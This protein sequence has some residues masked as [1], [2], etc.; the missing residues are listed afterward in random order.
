VSQFGFPPKIK[1]ISDLA[2]E[3]GAPFNMPPKVSHVPGH[4]CTGEAMSVPARASLEALAAA[5]LFALAWSLMRINDPSKGAIPLHVQ[6]IGC[7][8]P[9][10]SSSVER[11][12][13]SAGISDASPARKISI[14][15]PACVEAAV[16][17]A[18]NCAAA[19]DLGALNL[20]SAR[21]ASAACCSACATESFSSSVCFVSSALRVLCASSSFFVSYLSR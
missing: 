2:A 7:Q 20:S 12:N 4:A 10:P 17:I 9:D 5:T 14:E 18:A 13:A 19:R 1:R 15:V 6:V 8:L 16:P 3:N 21:V 11:L